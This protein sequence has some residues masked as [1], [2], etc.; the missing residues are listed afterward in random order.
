MLTDSDFSHLESKIRD[1]VYE[2][3]GNQYQKVYNFKTDLSSNLQQ[4]YSNRLM[5][6]IS[7][8]IDQA[9]QEGKFTF[10]TAPTSGVVVYQTDGYEPL[11]WRMYHPILLIPDICLSLI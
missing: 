8:Q 10:Y 3:D 11:H 1:F 6:E 2:Y 5:D 4:Y 7:A 9:T